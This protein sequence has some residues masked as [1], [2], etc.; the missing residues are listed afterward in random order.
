MNRIP[1]HRLLGV[2]L[3]AAMLLRL[4]VALAIGDPR[5]PGMPGILL[6]P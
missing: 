6:K 3:G 1:K 4:G 5:F 2:I